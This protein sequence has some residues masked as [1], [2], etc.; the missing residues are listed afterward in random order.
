MSYIARVEEVAAGRSKGLPDDVRARSYPGGIPDVRVVWDC[1]QLPVELPV[2][3]DDQP[4]GQLPGP[5]GARVSVT[6]FPPGWEGEMFWSSRVDILWV[7]SGE[8]TYMTDRGDEIV[9]GQGDLLIQN[10]AN[11]AFFNR[12]SDPVYMGAVMLGAIQAGP[13]PPLEQYHGPP[14]ALRYVEEPQP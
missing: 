9:V 12:G 3:P 2:D 6:I 7:M 14:E 4:S 1:E 10:G 5:R 13:T 8:L 11:K